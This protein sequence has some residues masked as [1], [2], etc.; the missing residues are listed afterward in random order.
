[1]GIKKIDMKI[2]GIVLLLAVALFSV[3]CRK[4][5]MVDCAQTE[6]QKRRQE[7]VG[8]WAV[9]PVKRRY[10]KDSLLDVLTYSVDLNYEFKDDGT[11]FLPNLDVTI[12]TDE[13]EW[14][15]QDEPR[16][17]MV[18]RITN[19]GENAPGGMQIYSVLEVKEDY[20]HW[21]YR[22]TAGFWTP[23]TIYHGY[24]EIEWEMFRR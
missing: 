1:M 17:V 7:I 12:D 14:M 2:K 21:M 3:S 18:R 15:Y 8:K 23:D 19:N 5:E 22:D 11:G 9:R 13:F 16:K 24:L 10:S 6:Y 20:M 4:K